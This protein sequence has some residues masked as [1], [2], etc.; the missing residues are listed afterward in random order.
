MTP[1][2]RRR[3][4]SELIALTVALAAYAVVQHVQEKEKQDRK[5]KRARKRLLRK[6]MVVR[7]RARLRAA[8]VDVDGG[9]IK[10]E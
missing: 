5:R 4:H 3:H 10:D 7:Q 6:R 2:Y 1:E 9:E 8:G